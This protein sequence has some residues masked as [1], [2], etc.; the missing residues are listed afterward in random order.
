M[1]WF[2]TTVEGGVCGYA[3]LLWADNGKVYHHGSQGYFSG[4]AAGPSWPLPAAAAFTAILGLAIYK[5]RLK[6]HK[7][8]RGEEAVKGKMVETCI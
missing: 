3:V 7:G 2:S 8:S 4:G 6:T 5:R 1:A